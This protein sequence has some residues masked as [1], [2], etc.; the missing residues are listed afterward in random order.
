MTKEMMP[1]LRDDTVRPRADTPTAAPAED[2]LLRLQDELQPG[3]VN[4]PLQCT[5]HTC[6]LTI[7]GIVQMCPQ[8]GARRDWMVICNRNE[9]SIRCRCA[10]QWVERE[11][12]RADFEAMAGPVNEV[13]K[14]TQAAVQALGYDG[15]LAGAYWA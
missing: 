2:P 4:I 12:S 13:F 6:E 8:C 9:V 1:V 11:L 14:T 10:H 7:T 15:D 3:D 5:T